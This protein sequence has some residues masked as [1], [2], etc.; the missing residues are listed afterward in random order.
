MQPICSRRSF[1]AVT[2]GAAGAVL[3]GACSKPPASGT[4][5]GDGS[6]TIN[7]IFG[8]TRIPGPPKSVV[9]AGLTGQDE[10]LAVGVVPIAVT[11]WFGN[12][13]FAVWPWAQPQL[14]QAQPA[15]L[16]LTDGIQVDKISA[17]KPDLIIAT[18]AGLDADT[19]K[20]LSA[21]APTV[22]Q[23]GSDAFF[24][25]WKDQATVIGQAVFKADDMKKLIAG[26]DAKFAGAGKANPLLSGRKMLIVNGLPTADGFEV[27]PAGWRT[28]FLSEM[29]IGTP[30]GLDT[31]VKGQHALVPRDQLATALRD[32]DVL[33]WT[34]DNDDQ[35]P[36]VLADPTV[37]QLSQAK[38]NRIVFPGKDLSAAIAFA[39]VLSYS[40]VAD[41]L[42]P[43][44]AKALT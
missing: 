5:A 13:P 7:H 4:V 26:V 38:A 2:A 30:D 42:P 6:V 25:P 3:V 34:L 18:D 14:G 8:T 24:E 40:A 10:L 12:Q 11:E 9:C 20:K 17:L 35:R 32:A 1:L 37:A 41:Q 44:L 15:V 43:L 29:G 23:S 27:T 39:S 31:F 33:I 36:A 16:S 28:E 21:I 22:A 19:Y